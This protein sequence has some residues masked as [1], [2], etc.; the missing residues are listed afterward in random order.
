M[1]THAWNRIGGDFACR[2]AGRIA[3]G[4]APRPEAGADPLRKSG[5]P[6]VDEGDGAQDCKCGSRTVRGPLLCML[7]V[8]GP[9]PQ[10]HNAPLGRRSFSCL[11][12]SLLGPGNDLCAFAQHCDRSQKRVQCEPHDKY[13]PL[14]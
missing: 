2:I 5:F 14:R 10:L 8:R 6:Q 13:N 3:G 4:A 9:R 12:P 7:L 11:I 1:A